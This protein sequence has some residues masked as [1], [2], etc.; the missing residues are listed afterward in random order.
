[1]NYT[2]GEKLLN[3]CKKRRKI[4]PW[5]SLRYSPSWTRSGAAP[6]FWR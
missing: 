5:F 6:T 4:Y 3:T 2:Q 1:L